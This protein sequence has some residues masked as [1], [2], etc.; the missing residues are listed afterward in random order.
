MTSADVPS[1]AID[2]IIL[3]PV[4]PFTGK[5]ISM[6]EKT[7]HDQFVIISKDWTVDTNNG[8][9]FN[10]AGWAAVT[11]NIWDRSDWI[12]TYDDIVLKEHE[13]PQQKGN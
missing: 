6:E 8:N 4:N 11:N 10:A 1:L 2:D 9:A 7:A 5:P 3:N 12:F 13:L